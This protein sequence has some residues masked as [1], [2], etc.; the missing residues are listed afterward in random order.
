MKKTF[1]IIVLI[2]LIPL[3]MIAESYTSLWKKYQH[4][5]DISHPQTAISVLDKIMVKGYR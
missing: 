4:N 2:I 5:I 3:A 1:L